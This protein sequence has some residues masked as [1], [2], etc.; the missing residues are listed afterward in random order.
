M[1]SRI[2]TDAYI[3]SSKTG[4][5]TANE[6]TTIPFAGRFEI[7][8]HNVNRDNPWNVRHGQGNESVILNLRNDFAETMAWYTILPI[9]QS[10]DPIDGDGLVTVQVTNTSAIDQAGVGNEFMA[11]LKGLIELTPYLNHEQI[12]SMYQLAG[13]PKPM[14]GLTMPLIYQQTT[15]ATTETT[16][17]LQAPGETVDVAKASSDKVGKWLAEKKQILLDKIK[18]S[19][20]TGQI[21]TITLSGMSTLAASLQLSEQAKAELRLAEDVFNSTMRQAVKSSNMMKR[22]TTAW[23]TFETEVREWMD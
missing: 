4:L 15:Q 16:P 11:V 8:V 1:P 9:G 20:S 7:T 5:P 19:I 13:I 23:Q 14:Q 12:D 17:A 6:P 21:P 2:Y 3:I 18:D 10:E 22:F